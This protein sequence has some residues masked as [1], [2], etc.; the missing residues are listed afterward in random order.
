MTKQKSLAK[1]LALI[2]KGIKGLRDT[3]NNERQFTID[4]RLVGDI[5]EVIVAIEYKVVL[6]KTSQPCYD[7]TSL[8]GRRVQIKATFQNQLT[9]KIVPDYYIGLKLNE[10][11]T[12]EEVYNGPGKYIRERYSKRKGIGVNLLRF[13]VSELKKLQTN[14]NKD[15][16]IPRRQ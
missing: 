12:Y 9:F 10:N 1:S 3:F 11:G 7:A 8:D 15:E 6:D 16:K 5:G 2:F 4:G 13:P 14:V